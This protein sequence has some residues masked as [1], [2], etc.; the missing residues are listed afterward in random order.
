MSD[1]GW[2]DDPSGRFGKRWYDG[3]AWSGHVVGANGT[4]TTDALP[5]RDAPY[6]PPSALARQEPTAPPQS[7]PPGGQAWSSPGAAPPPGYGA[8]AYGP[9]PPYGPPA[10]YG[11][12]GPYGPRAPKPRLAP[13]PGLIVGLVGIVCLGLSLFVLK[14]RDV[15]EGT[16]LDTSSKARDV[17]SLDGADAGL[18]IAITYYAW[19]GFVLFAL[20]LLLVL[21]A[22]IPVPTTSS[23]GQRIVGSVVAGIGGVLHTV[24]TS[25]GE[26]WEFGAYLG[27][28][29][30]FV[31]IVGF[32][33]GVRQKQPAG[34]G[35]PLGFGA[36]PPP[37]AG[38]P[39]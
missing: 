17:E 13:G 20:T 16:F 5:E 27:A 1:A 3:S 29:G 12:P 25:Q 24:T 38:A 21:A 10:P 35:G 34:P 32:V 4:A 2:F 14:W 18:K 7:S 9:P 39:Q 30:F 33:L 6:P 26:D 22:G 8:P 37:Y 11:A 19:A 28:I 31:C 15:S 23:A 36:A